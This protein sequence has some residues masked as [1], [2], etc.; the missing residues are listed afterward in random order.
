MIVRPGAH[1]AYLKFSTS[2]ESTL[3]IAGIRSRSDPG[4]Q[5]IHAIMQVLALR[6]FAVFRLTRSRLSPNNL[7]WCPWN[8]NEF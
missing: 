7:T 5:L 2:Q 3:Q 6:E 4:Q 1:F 8:S